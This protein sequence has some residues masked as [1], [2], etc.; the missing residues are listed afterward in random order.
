MATLSTADR[1]RIWRGLMRYW[2]NL[3]E[4]TDVGKALLLTLVG[5]TDQWIDDNAAS[6]NS[7]LSVNSLTATQKTLLFCAV[8]LLRV[9][10]GL[11][12]LLRRALGVEVN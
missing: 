6:Y 3:R 9:D 11:A 4:T 12:V 1:Q 8:A 5:E 2:S 10:P 7:A